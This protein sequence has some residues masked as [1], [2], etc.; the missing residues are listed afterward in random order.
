MQWKGKGV[1]SLGEEV[2]LVCIRPKRLERY[3]AVR[4]KHTGGEHIGR[5]GGG[6]NSGGGERRLTALGW[7]G[8]T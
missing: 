2:H 5:G 4:D 1:V 7:D 3:N 8:T 6:K